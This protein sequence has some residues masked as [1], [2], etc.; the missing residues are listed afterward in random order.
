MTLLLL[1]RNHLQ[2]LFV[3]DGI[4]RIQ[5]TDH[6]LSLYPTNPA[7]VIGRVLLVHENVDDLGR[8]GNALSKVN[9]NAGGRLACGVIGYK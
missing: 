4:A 7:F 8:G 3:D 2:F 5:F 9:G 6:V 1:L